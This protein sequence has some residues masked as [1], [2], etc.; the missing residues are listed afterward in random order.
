MTKRGVA[1]NFVQA[2]RGARGER[3]RMPDTRAL[4]WT[5]SMDRRDALRR[6]AATTFAGLACCTG[7]SALDAVSGDGRL[8]AR[9]SAPSGT[10]TPGERSLGLASGRDGLW[11]VPA[12]YQGTMAAPLALLLHGAGHDAHELMNPIRP[13]ADTLGLVL[14]APDSRGASWD[15]RYGTYGPDIAYIDAALAYVFDRVTVDARRI[16]VIGFSDGASYAL[17]IGRING[18]LFRRVVAF[19]P[20]YV[21]PGTPTGKPEFFITHG[22]QDTVLPIEETSRKIVPSLRAAGYSVEY[23]E[24]DGGHG[25]T[26]A[27]LEQA[28]RWAAR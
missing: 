28:V 7:A 14:I 11:F 15:L 24:F 5:A 18:D 20:G 13:V 19:S 25:V 2:R 8:H 21:G 27:L 4:D 23:H 10:A 12:S 3:A 22:T 26:P 1:A 17:S 6:L 16:S 9:P